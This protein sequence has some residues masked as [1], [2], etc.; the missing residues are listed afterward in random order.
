MGC[1]TAVDPSLGLQVHL[2]KDFFLS[3]SVS[4]L[5]E[6]Q[7][8]RNHEAAAACNPSSLIFESN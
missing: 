6:T 8:Q 5:L 7:E 3:G 1:G 2:L 4:L